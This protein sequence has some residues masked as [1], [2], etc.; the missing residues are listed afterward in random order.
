MRDFLT[1]EVLSDAP[2]MTVSLNYE[3]NH[4]VCLRNS[5]QQAH[6]QQKEVSDVS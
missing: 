1:V 4:I 2:T 5:C 3:R 6:D